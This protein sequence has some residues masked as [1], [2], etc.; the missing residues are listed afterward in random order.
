MARPADLSPSY[1]RR[2]GS[3]RR[4]TH[5]IGWRRP[6]SG[7]R[8][9][10]FATGRALAAAIHVQRARR[11]RHAIAD[12]PASCDR[13]RLRG[14]QRSDRLRTTQ[15]SSS[16]AMIL[17]PA[18]PRQ[19]RR[20]PAICVA[21]CSAS[22]P[23]GRPPVSWCP[24]TATTAARRRERDDIRTRRA[25][26]RKPVLR[27]YAETRHKAKSW[28]A[29]RRTCADRGDRHG[30]RRTLVVTNLGDVVC[31]VVERASDAIMISLAWR[32]CR[33]Q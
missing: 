25:L 1:A 15:P 12:A 19:A 2:W 17:R 21:S 11:V 26:K 3:S 6:A 31:S 7:G 33:W 20:S 29:G 32:L 10:A 18:R 9:A 14:C 24:A 28:R 23:A 4:R 5:D 27:G 13:L 8:R 16:P 30:L 22:A